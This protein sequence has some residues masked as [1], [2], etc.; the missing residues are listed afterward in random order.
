VP[1]VPTVWNEAGPEVDFIF[2]DIKNLGFRE[3][4]IDEIYVFHVFEHLF[5]SEIPAAV[6]NWRS[7]LK[8]N[9]E[10]YIV[11]DDYEFICRAFVGGE[12]NVDEFN[13]DFS[14]PTKISRENIVKYLEGA[15]FSQHDMKFWYVDVPN[16]FPKKEHEI[17]VS[18]K[19]I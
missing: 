19:K 5:E 3:E 16:L 17:V 8:K 11:S 15:G 10:M 12:F 9:A 4:S 2:K 1:D 18:G 7:L 14:Y 6:A 13:R